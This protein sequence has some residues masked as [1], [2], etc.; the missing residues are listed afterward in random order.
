[1]KYLN[2]LLFITVLILLSSC[3]PKVSTSLTKT[4][5]ALDYRD[6]VIVIG[7]S[8]Q[9]PENSEYI[10]EVKITD[11]GFSTKC[12]YDIV[13]NKAKLAARKAGGNAIKIIEHRLPSA[14]GSTC[15]RITARILKTDTDFVAKELQE[16]I[17]DVDYAILN[18]YRYGGAGSLVSYDLHLGDSVIC[19]VQNNFKTTLHIKKDGMNML[20]AKTES[21]SEVPVDF[22]MGRTYYLRCGIAMGAFVG[23]PQLDLIDFK[24]GKTEFESFNAKNQ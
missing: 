21:K 3:N 6:E 22:E 23:K 11:T 10:G 17:L 8:Q 4:L 13:I 9:E 20:W 24:T 14:L 15:H 18:V 19:R 12:G 7:L 1:M 16:P 2:R 5:P